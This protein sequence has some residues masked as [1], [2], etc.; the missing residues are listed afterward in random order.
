MNQLLVLASKSPRRQTL[1][2]QLGYRFS[3]QNADVDESVLPDESS[4]A[5]VL[6]VA[7]AKAQ[8]IATRLTDQQHNHDFIVLGAD[9]CVVINGEILS[10]PKDILDSQRMLT[11]LSNRQHQVLTAIAIV[12]KDKVKST[13]VKTAVFFKPLSTQEIL[14]YWQT[15]EPQDKAGSYALQGIAGR[16]I[17][18]IQGSYSAVIGLPL[19]ETEQL[20]STCQLYNS[21]NKQKEV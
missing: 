2:A 14:Q 5:Y 12:E 6:R 16:F 21:L 17:T 10:K 11:L 19:Y 7:I 20:L 3:C 1:L 15:G 8:T 9:T 13:V 18:H 4:E